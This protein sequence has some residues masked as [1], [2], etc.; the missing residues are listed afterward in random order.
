MVVTGARNLSEPVDLEHQ[1]SIEA[2][3]ARVT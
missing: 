3:T 2:D 1:I